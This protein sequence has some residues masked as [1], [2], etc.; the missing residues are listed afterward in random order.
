MSRKA[1]IFRAFAVLV[2]IRLSRH[3][4]SNRNKKFVFVWRLEHPV[5]PRQHLKGVTGKEAVG[6]K[7]RQK[8][9]ELGLGVA[10]VA[11]YLGTSINTVYKW[12]SGDRFPRDHH[13]ERI[14]GFLNE[15]RSNFLFPIET[16]SSRVLIGDRIKQKMGELGLSRKALAELMGVNYVTV[17]H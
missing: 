1:A 7:M 2:R 13:L 16:S 6:E 11:R 14:Q 17:Y 9:S 3:T 15:D 12:E 8:R 4:R 5:V 10:E